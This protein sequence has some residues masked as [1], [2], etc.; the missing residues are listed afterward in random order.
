MRLSQLCLPL[1]LGTAALLPGC[2]KSSV[3]SSPE[4]AE[5][6]QELGDI[7]GLCKFHHEQK[8]RPPARL[9]DLKRS[10]IAFPGGYDA[11]A[12][13]RCILLWGTPWDNTPGG[14]SK[15]LAYEAAAAA[16]GGLVLMHDG[17]IRSMTADEL[18][19]ALNASR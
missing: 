9:A 18:Q 8:G 3:G 6:R 7:H 12:T 19:A 1:L 10:E 13:G 16:Q 15:V 11:L 17:T 2:G 5:R 14:R 4:S